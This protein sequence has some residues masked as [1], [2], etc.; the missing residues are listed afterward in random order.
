[1]VGRPCSRNVFDHEAA[2]VE[3]ALELQ[4]WLSAGDSVHDPFDLRQVALR[5]VLV[6]QPPERR[7]YALAAALDLGQFHDERGRRPPELA[8]NRGGTQ[9]D[10]DRLAAE[11]EA[12][13]V[14]SR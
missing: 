3:H 4:V 5:G 2:G 13:D 14:G 7:Q 10:D 12:V 8:Q 1:M 9:A 6:N 11:Y